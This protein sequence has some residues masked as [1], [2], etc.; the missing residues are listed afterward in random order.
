MVM[1]VAQDIFAPKIKGWWYRDLRWIY[2][3]SLEKRTWK[4]QWICNRI[5]NYNRSV[6][7]SRIYSGAA[8]IF[9]SFHWSKISFKNYNGL[10]VTFRVY[11]GSVMAFIN[12]NGPANSFK[13]NNGST[14]AFKTTMDLQTHSK[15]ITD[16]RLRSKLQ[17]I[18]N[19]IQSL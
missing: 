7:T 16:L 1:M 15:T 19:R 12:Y 17:W 10:A 9:R 4:L 2:H 8:I 5:P 13:N 6:M 3:H 18:C 11:K 14:I